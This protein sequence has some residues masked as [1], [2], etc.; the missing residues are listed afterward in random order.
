[1]E[2]SGQEQ[3]RV[4]KI[5]DNLEKQYFERTTALKYSNHFELLIAVILSAQTT[6][7]QVNKVT[8]RL[9]RQFSTP[10]DFANLTLEQLEKEI[11]GVGLAKTKS[12]NIIETCKLLISD[13][14]SMIPQDRE[15]LMRLPGVGRK[16]AN[17]IISVAFGQPAL[18][19]DTHVHRLAKRL[20]LSSGKNV[21]QTEQDLCSLIPR[22]KWSSAHHWLIWHGREICTAKNPLCSGCKL[23]DLCPYYQDNLKSKGGVVN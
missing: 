12:K 21:L 8:D 19:V 14:G 17:V 20:G 13:Y 2:P 16:T 10:E 18:A 6:D 7:R 1:M 11:K 3:S 23:N 9:F 15:E 22:E 4:K 5:I